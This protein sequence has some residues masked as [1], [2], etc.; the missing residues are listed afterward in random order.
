[1]AS[2]LKCPSVACESRC[3]CPHSPVA[4]RLPRGTGSKRAELPAT[5]AER[6][7]AVKNAAGHG[8]DALEVCG[9][10]PYRY[11]M[12]QPRI[13]LSTNGYRALA[14]P[15]GTLFVVG[16]GELALAAL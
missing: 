2:R 12:R 8:R 4:I 7:P 13:L 3:A 1:M 16:Q 9:G 5:R 6:G 10:S 11:E 15:H 14:G